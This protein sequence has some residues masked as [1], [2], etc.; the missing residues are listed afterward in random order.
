MASSL[1]DLGYPLTPI[2]FLVG[3]G[4][5]LG[6]AVQAKPLEGLLGLFLTLFGLPAYWILEPPGKSELRE[7][8]SRGGWGKCVREKK[9]GRPATSELSS[10]RGV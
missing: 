8:P 7:I 9:P 1:P 10:F 6:M 2:L 3:N 5:F 4:V